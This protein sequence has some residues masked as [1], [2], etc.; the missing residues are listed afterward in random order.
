MNHLQHPNLVQFY[1]GESST[2]LH[3][4]PWLVTK[5]CRQGTLKQPIRKNMATN[6]WLQEPSLKHIGES[7]ARAVD[8]LHHGP[9]DLPQ[10]WDP[11]THRDIIL[12]NVFS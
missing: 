11:V 7:L 10:A 4:T 9:D 5:Y 6:V 2:N 12:G 1:D 8:Y 3:R